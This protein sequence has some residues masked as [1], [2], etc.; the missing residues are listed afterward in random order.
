MNKITFAVCGA[1]GRMGSSIIRLASADPVLEFAGGVEQKGNLLIGTP[2]GTGTI[3]D[4]LESVIPPCNVVID[5]SSP[6]SAIENL[7]VVQKHRK[8]MVIGTTGISEEGIAKIREASKSIPIVYT[9]NMS[10][11][12]NLLFKLAK[13]VAA[14]LPNYDVEIVELH[15]N[16]K[17]D[18]PSGTA[19]TL[20]G[21]IAGALGRDIDSV[22]VYGR[23]GLVGA[24]KKEEIGVH[25]VRA[26]DIVG[27]HTA[28]RPF[29]RHLR[30]GCDRCREMGQRAEA[31]FVRYAG[32]S[33][34][35]RGT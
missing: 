7:A 16:Q 30:R 13:D 33:H 25:A 31:G 28:P 15:H 5:F 29:S 21:E 3:T 34:Q 4:C 9:S 18:S 20:A 19:L 24:R 2:L 22:G 11:G 26:G 10:V 12:V 14:L 6:Q 35:V 27:E 8:A 1:A 17:K 23:H 32:R